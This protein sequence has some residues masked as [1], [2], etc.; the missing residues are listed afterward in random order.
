MYLNQNELTIIYNGSHYKSKQTLCYA[1]SFA[2][3]VNQQNFMETRISMN[4]FCLLLDKTGAKPKDL[5]NRASRYYQEELRNRDLTDEEWFYVIKNGPEIMV[6]PL[7]FY[8]GNG[9]VCITP[10]DVLKLSHQD[11]IL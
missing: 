10:S 3:K 11:F 8:K 7:V 9:L 1:K 6:N 4:L 2:Q 5:V